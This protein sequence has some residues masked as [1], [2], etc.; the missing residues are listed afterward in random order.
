VLPLPPQP[1][2]R[3][4]CNQVAIQLSQAQALRLELTR[5]RGAASA[6]RQS[7]LKAAFSGQ[8]VPQDP[9]DEPA[10]ALLARLAAQAAEAPAAPRRRGRPAGRRL[11]QPNP[12]VAE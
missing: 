2:A 1:E 12:A 4:I 5:R 9:R 7:I 10:S 3:E 8:L 6:L 11:S